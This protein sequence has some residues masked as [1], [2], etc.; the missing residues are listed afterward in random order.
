[1]FSNIIS[2]QSFVLNYITN[3]T[4]H[5]LVMEIVLNSFIHN[6]YVSCID[7]V[8]W[9]HIWYINLCNNV[10]FVWHSFI[11]KF[12]LHLLIYSCVKH[13][14]NTWY[15]CVKFTNLWMNKLH[16]IFIINSSHVKFVMYMFVFFCFKVKNL[17]SSVKKL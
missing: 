5:D 6:S 8:H 11:H 1:M 10:K 13:V 15:L 4:S 17:S 9:K 2:G 14:F 7:I 12:V 3:L 16:M